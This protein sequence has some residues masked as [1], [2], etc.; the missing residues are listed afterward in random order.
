MRRRQWSRGSG[1]TDRAI[2]SGP[3]PRGPSLVGGAARCV[4][5]SGAS[6]LT[7]RQ[8]IRGPSPPL[9]GL[10]A[11]LC[12]LRL[13]STWVGIT[14]CTRPWLLL[15]RA[16]KP[17]GLDQHRGKG[18]C[19]RGQHSNHRSRQVLNPD[20]QHLPLKGPCGI[21][22]GLAN[23]FQRTFGSV[24]APHASRVGY[25]ETTSETRQSSSLR[26]ARTDRSCRAA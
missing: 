26:A 2:G 1:W 16:P 12:P 14:R 25:S 10:P 9:D 21:A 5:D 7:A 20:F 15:P 17:F 18:I 8:S 11:S 4:L 22:H 13:P 24:Q 3:R 23:R 6:R 19:R